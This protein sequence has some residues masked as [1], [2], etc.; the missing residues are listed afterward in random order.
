MMHDE[1]MDSGTTVEGAGFAGIAGGAIGVAPFVIVM[2]AGTIRP[3]GDEQ[4]HS[5]VA[6]AAEGRNG[7]QE[8]SR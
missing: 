1:W 6:T 2:T 7:M 4:A 3:M 5:F 8:A